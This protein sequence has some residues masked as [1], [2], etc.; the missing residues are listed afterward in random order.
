MFSIPL[1]K[2]LLGLSKGK[3]NSIISTLFHIKTL[4]QLKH[5]NNYYITIMTEPSPDDSC[6]ET[7]NCDFGVQCPSKIN[8]D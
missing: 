7:F 4:A 3:K 6:F 8:C 1:K 5:T 2:P